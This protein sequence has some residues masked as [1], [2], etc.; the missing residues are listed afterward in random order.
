MHFL[1]FATVTASLFS[2][3][4]AGGQCK[5]GDDFCGWLLV[6]SRGEC[7]LVLQFRNGNLI[8]QM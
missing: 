5:P 7:F 8:D 4:I 2:A 3:A 6:D 1:Y